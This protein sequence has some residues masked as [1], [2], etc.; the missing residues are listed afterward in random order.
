MNGSDRKSEQTKELAERTKRRL[1]EVR[2]KR[3]REER[4]RREEQSKRDKDKNADALAPPKAAAKDD[5][6]DD[7][8]AQPAPMLATHIPRTHELLALSGFTR[9]LSWRD[10]ARLRSIERAARAL[11][12]ALRRA[13]PAC[14]PYVRQ[15]C[16]ALAH[17]E[18][19]A[20]LEL[21]FEHQTAA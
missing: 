18:V 5:A 7:G 1:L 2:E 10:R 4:E 20:R 17:I 21:L 3:E 15:S 9:P 8:K 14:T 12:R 19:A 6:D 16:D 11:R 13:F